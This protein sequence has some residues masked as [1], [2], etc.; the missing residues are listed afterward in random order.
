M[1]V[2]STKEDITIRLVRLTGSEHEVDGVVLSVTRQLIDG[3]F[4]VGSPHTKEVVLDLES[5]VTL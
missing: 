1:G 4:P 3:G 2:L 5:E